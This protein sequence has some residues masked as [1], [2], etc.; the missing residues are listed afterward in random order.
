[1]LW[2]PQLCF[3]I[4]CVPTIVGYNISSWGCSVGVLDVRQF[5]HKEE[6]EWENHNGVKIPDCD[7]EYKNTLLEVQDQNGMFVLTDEPFNRRREQSQYEQAPLIKRILEINDAPSWKLSDLIFVYD[8]CLKHLI[9]L[10]HNDISVNLT[11]L[12]YDRLMQTD[13]WKKQKGRN[14]I[15]LLSFVGEIYQDRYRCDKMKHAMHGFIE[16]HQACGQLLPHNVIIPFLSNH[17][18]KEDKPFQNRTKLLCYRGAVGRDG[19]WGKRL[20]Y[21]S[22]RFFRKLDKDISVNDGYKADLAHED[23]MYEY[24]DCK[25]CLTLAGDTPSSRRLNE[26][27]SGGCIPIFLGP[28]FQLI[29]FKNYINWQNLGIFIYIKNQPW[30]VPSENDS[31]VYEYQPYLAPPYMIQMTDL[32]ELPKYLRSITT[33][34]ATNYQRKVIKYQSM[35]EY[36]PNPH[37]YPSAIDTMMKHFCQAYKTDWSFVDESMEV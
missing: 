21:W 26:I 6:L 13:E 4:I 1:M 23:L 27:I 29:F 25:Y 15:F 20:R 35:V 18:I 10:R 12:A 7:L 33:E 3:L 9:K 2:L 24:Q 17:I 31:W 37:G 11:K 36:L 16:E 14:F 22:M 8:Y 32:H 5:L 34:Q 28:P 30:S 19:P